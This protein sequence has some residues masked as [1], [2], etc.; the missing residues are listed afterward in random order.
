MAPYTKLTKGQVAPDFTFDT[1]WETGKSLYGSLGGKKTFLL[2]LRYRGCTICQLAIHRLIEEY[3]LFT[4][5]GAQVLVVLQS[6]PAT[7]AGQDKAEDFPFTIVCDPK[8]EL[9]HLYG[10]EPAKNKLGMASVKTIKEIQQSKKMGLTHGKYEGNELQLP[11]VMLIEPD[12]TLSFV[13]YGKSAADLP[14]NQELAE[15]L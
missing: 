10:V 1:P 7:I 13:H 4:D 9:Y 12:T 2:F 8:E 11:A 3:H 6:E 5:K 15:L 14:S